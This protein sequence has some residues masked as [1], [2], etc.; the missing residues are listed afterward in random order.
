MCEISELFYG[1]CSGKARSYRENQREK[2][3]SAFEPSQVQ[4][5]ADPL[6][7]GHSC[8]LLQIH[9]PFS[10]ILQSLSIRIPSIVKREPETVYYRLYPDIRRNQKNNFSAENERGRRL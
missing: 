5:T 7:S 1:G 8:G 10:S 2:G 6:V 4:L 3:T 9:R